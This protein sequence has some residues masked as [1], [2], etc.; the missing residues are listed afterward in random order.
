MSPLKYL[1]LDFNSYFASVEQQRMPE[2]R[3]KPVAIVPVMSDATCAIAASYEAKAYGIKTGTPVWEAKKKCPGLICVEA[4]HKHYVEYHNK[5][6]DEIDKHIPVSAIHSI[7]EMSCE[8]QGKECTEEGGIALAKQ[9]KRGLA[10]NPEIG[11]YVRCSIGLSTNRYL[12]KVATNLQKPDGLVIL[13]PEAVRE[14]LAHI[15]LIDLPGIGYNMHRRL[16]RAGIG[17]ID[18]FMRLAPKQMRAIWGSVEGERFWYKMRGVELAPFATEKRSIGH[19]HV[20]APELRPAPEA[21]HVAQRLLLKAASRLRRMNMLTNYMVLSV[22]VENG[23]RLS[24][25]MRFSPVSDNPAL[26]RHLIVLWQALVTQH[27]FTRIKKVSVTFLSLVEPKVA[28]QPTLFDKS[29]TPRAL[30]RAQAANRLS[31]AMDR[32]NGKYGRDTIVMGFTP[33]KVHA[34]SGTK[35]AFTRIPDL[36]EFHE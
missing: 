7:D 1:F 24:V 19:S 29:P 5:I 11:R 36:E 21:W 14:R 30:Y 10:E 31:A 25:E 22:R 32:L 2:L 34:F 13:P 35:I 27:K 18:T 17:D 26:M 12:A 6:L 28:Q 4:D 33:Q 15:S 3:G 16:L 8:L 9:I 20:L 23:P